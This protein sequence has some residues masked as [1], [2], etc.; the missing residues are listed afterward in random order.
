MPKE[1]PTPPEKGAKAATPKKDTPA[2]DKA[3]AT[4][5]EPKQRRSKFAEMYPEA[6]KITVIVE[7]N[8]KKEGSASRER[9]E[10]YFKSTT[11]GDFL[12]AGG[13]YADV[14]YDIGRMHISVEVVQPAAP[15]ATVK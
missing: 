6:S 2:N 13:T 3:T 1:A 5:A 4:P 8:P 10:H 15:A 14:A 11:I 9:F 12:A 7:A